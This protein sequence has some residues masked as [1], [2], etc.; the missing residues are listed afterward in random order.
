MQ[1]ELLVNVDEWGPHMED[2]LRRYG[3]IKGKFKEI[4][5]YA[6]T[7]Y[8][9]GNTPEERTHSYGWLMTQLSKENHIKRVKEDSGKIEPLFVDP[10]TIP[11]KSVYA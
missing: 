7:I 8:P 5:T 9:E 6:L 11:I 3:D 10:L 4:K 1:K 2:T